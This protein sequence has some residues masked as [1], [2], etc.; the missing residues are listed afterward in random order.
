MSVVVL[1]WICWLCR[2]PVTPADLHHG[3]CRRCQL[4]AGVPVQRHG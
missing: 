4:V 1:A 2:E 3:L